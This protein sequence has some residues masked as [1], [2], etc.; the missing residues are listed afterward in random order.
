MYT[1]KEAEK[2][3]ARNFFL[4]WDGWN[5]KVIDPTKDGFCKP[6]GYY[7]NGKWSVARTIEPN[8]EGKYDIPRKYSRNIESTRH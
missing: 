6:N 7:Y 3:V 1:L 5:I 8:Q 2:I 4:D